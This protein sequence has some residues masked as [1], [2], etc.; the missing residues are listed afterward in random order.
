MRVE[1]S[2][3]CAFRCAAYTAGSLLHDLVYKSQI[4]PRVKMTPHLGV[5][6]LEVN[7]GLP[8]VIIPNHNACCINRHLVGQKDGDIQFLSGDSL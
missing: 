5:T 3:P 7:A 4:Q 8:V 6:E 2:T 1:R